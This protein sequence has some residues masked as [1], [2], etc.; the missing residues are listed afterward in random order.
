MAAA[1]GSLWPVWSSR[2][3][4][5][6]HTE[7]LVLVFPVQPPSR[8]R[9]LGALAALAGPISCTAIGPLAKCRGCM[10]LYC[11]IRTAACT[12]MYCGSTYVPQYIRRR[13]GLLECAR[14]DCDKAATTSR[15]RRRR[16][17]ACDERCESTSDKTRLHIPRYVLAAAARLLKSQGTAWSAPGGSAAGGTETTTWLPVL[18]FGADRL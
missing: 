6:V 3:P 9:G 7:Y 2:G 18:P 13:A 11:C 15:R 1:T 14:L 12:S 17:L 8:V 4:Y 10:P 16:R 5:G